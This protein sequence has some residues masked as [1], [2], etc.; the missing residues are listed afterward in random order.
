MCGVSEALGFQDS[1]FL[2]FMLPY[3]LNILDTH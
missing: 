3:F 1:N 2:A